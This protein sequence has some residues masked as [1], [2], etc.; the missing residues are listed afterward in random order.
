MTASNRA[1]VTR[2]RAEHRLGHAYALG[3][4]DPLGLWNTAVRTSLTATSADHW[5]LTQGG[6]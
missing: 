1:H 3:S 5:E 6:C 2:G 4:V